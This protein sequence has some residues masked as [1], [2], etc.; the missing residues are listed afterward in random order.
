MPGGRREFASLVLLLNDSKEKGW[1]AVGCGLCLQWQ[2]A[3]LLGGGASGCL[4]VVLE[5]YLRRFS[6]RC[7]SSVI[8]DLD[9]GPGTWDLGPGEVPVGVKLRKRKVFF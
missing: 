3:W 6:R 5:L 1:M 9:V 4:S 8:W 7:S 2:C